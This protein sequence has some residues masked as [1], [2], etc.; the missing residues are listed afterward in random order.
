M[1]SKIELQA[2]LSTQPV[3]LHATKACSNLIGQ[4]YRDYK[5]TTNG[6]QTVKNLCK[7]HN[8]DGSKTSDTVSELK[9]LI[10]FI[11]TYFHNRTVILL[12]SFCPHMNALFDFQK[13]GLQA[14]VI[15]ARE[16]KEES[17]AQAGERNL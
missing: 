9:V 15:Q 17:T 11:L 13:R 16:E 5:C 8:V 3:Y 10:L 7:N 6:N 12:K 4:Y 1:G 2:L 14:K